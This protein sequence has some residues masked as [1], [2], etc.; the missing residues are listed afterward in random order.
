MP[1]YRFYWLD[2]NDKISLAENRAC[3]D[4]LEALTL[5]YEHCTHFHIEAWHGGRRVFR[6]ERGSRAPK[7]FAGARSGG[8]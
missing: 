3:E 8:S 6:V 5:A 2:Q 4:D 7:E 1:V